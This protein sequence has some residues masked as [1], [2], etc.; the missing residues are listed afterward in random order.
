M[1]ISYL[2][3]MAIS[4]VAL[5]AGSLHASITDPGNCNPLVP[6]FFAD[7]FVFYDSST[8]YLYPTTDGYDDGTFRY[9]GPFGVWHSTDFVNW[10]FKTLSYPADF[11]WNNSR[12]WAPSVIR[13]GR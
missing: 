12:L 11:P 6:G 3:G 1:A 7:P 2:F 13:G 10:T 5:S 9:F 8:F 4:F